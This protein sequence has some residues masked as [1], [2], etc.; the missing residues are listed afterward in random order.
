MDRNEWYRAG[1]DIQDQVQRAVESG[2]FTDL[3]KNIGNTVNETLNHTVR[4]MNRT[5]GTVGESVN[6][7]VEIV[8]DSIS[9]RSMM[10]RRALRNSRFKS[11]QIPMP[12]FPST[13]VP[14]RGLTPDCFSARRR[15]LC[16]VGCIWELAMA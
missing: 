9:A 1:E 4:E 13:G 14:T 15:E 8:G 6:R 11:R 5:V 2:D 10:W 16:P 12:I 3:G 7:T